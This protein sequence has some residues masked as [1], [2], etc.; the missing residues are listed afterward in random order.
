[1][2]NTSIDNIRGRVA[3][4]KE[5]LRLKAKNDAREKKRS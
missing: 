1:M 3:Q 5:A 2:T 4:Q